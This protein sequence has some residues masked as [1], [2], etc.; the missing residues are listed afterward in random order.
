MNPHL[1][2]ARPCTDLAAAER[3]Y[4]EGLGLQVLYRA[5]ASAPGE[6]D[7]LMVGAPGAAWHLELVLGGTPAPTEEDLLVLYLGEPAAPELVDRLVACGGTVVSQ[8]PYWDRWAV[9]VRDRDGYRVAL[10][11]RTWVSQG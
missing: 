11:S 10:S 5:T 7:L 2:I 1:R 9:T 8:G 6:H 3:F 4:V